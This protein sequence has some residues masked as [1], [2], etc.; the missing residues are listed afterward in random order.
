VPLAAV[1]VLVSLLVPWVSPASSGRTGSQRADYAAAAGY[2]LVGADGGIFAYGGATFFGSMG[3]RPLD[4]PIDGI[5]PTPDGAGYWEVAS[6]GGIFAFGDATF[7]GSMG[8]KPLDAPIVGIAA[9]PDGGGYWEVA[10]DGGIFA[11][12]D[13]TFYGS[14]GGKPLDAPVVGIA[15]TST[16]GGYWEVA[17]DGGIFAFGDAAFSGSMGGRPLKA[18]IVGIAPT[19]DGGGYWEVAS[20]GGIFAFGD[21]AFYGSMGGKPLDAPVVGIAATPDGGG[22]WEVAADGGI[23]AFGDATFYGSMGGKPLD[24]PVVGIAP[25]RSAASG[26]AFVWAGTPTRTTAIPLGDGSVTTTPEVGSVDSCATSFGGGGAKSAG[27]W[28]DSTAGTWDAETKVH[29]EGVNAWP[30]AAHSFTLAGAERILATDDLP[31]GETT[32]N[33]PIASTDPAY[34]YDTNPNHVAAQTFSWSVQADPT[35][36][37]SPSCLGMGPIGVSIDGV[38]FFDALDAEGRD[39]GAYEVLDSCDGHPQSSDIYHYHTL[40]PC[41]ESAASDAPNSSTLIGYALDGYGIYIERDSRGDLPTDADL[42]AC[43]G[44][45]SAVTW[46]G[47]K[48]VM[49]HYDVSTE[50]PYT[51]GCYHATP[52]TAG[53][54]AALAASIAGQCGNPSNTAPGGYKE[55]AA[56]S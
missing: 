11:F 4:V 35:A 1:A 17:S 23:F 44:R 46:D 27:P 45:T 43:H 28:I 47:H 9:T 41:L 12:G 42:D 15:T 56:T 13:A 24:A 25:T 19:T 50:Y 51:V 55:S 32:G 8:G 16:G 22:Y 30:N 37:K 20:D 31:T 3:G 53:S 10:A 14:M 26:G 18:P 36:A 52:A 5:A 49:Y 40:S 2:R 54:P 6:D 39:A 48:T 21:A 38:V 7:Y 34:Q 33:F 29:V